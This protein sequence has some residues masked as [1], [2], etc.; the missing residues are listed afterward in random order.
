MEEK[1]CL[2]LEGNLLSVLY[3]LIPLVSNASEDSQQA[4]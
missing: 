1:M 2:S 4:N 3:N